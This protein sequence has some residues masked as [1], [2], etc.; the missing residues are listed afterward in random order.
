MLKLELS[1]G[2]ST[3]T[4]LEHEFLGNKIKEQNLHPGTKIRLSGTL[5]IRRGVILLSPKNVELLGGNVEELKSEVG[6]EQKLKSL[7]TAGS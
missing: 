7:L 5:N 3:V 6:L 2:F 4:A 1:D